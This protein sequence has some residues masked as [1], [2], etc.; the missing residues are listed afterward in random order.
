MERRF[1]MRVIP[2]ARMWRLLC[3]QAL[4]RLGLSNSLGW[5]LIYLN[6][7]GDDVRQAALAREVEIREATLVR[8][9]NQLES[10]GLVE[11]VPDPNDGRANNLRLTDKGKAIVGE[12]EARLAELRHELLADADEAKL[13][14]ALD[15]C[16]K[17][18]ARLAE[19]RGHP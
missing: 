2:M 5:C 16:E 7:L 17:L 3:D 6:R 8:T 13:A 1:A 15:V 19:R 4:A 14:V 11:R 10:S 9:L 12:I 18:S